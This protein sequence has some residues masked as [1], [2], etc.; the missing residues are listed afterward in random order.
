MG[1]NTPADKVYGR[2]GLEFP[3]DRHTA[4]AEDTFIVIP[5]DAPALSIRWKYG[6]GAGKPALPN[7]QESCHFL[8]FT[9]AIAKAGLTVR[10]VVS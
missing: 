4:A 3:A 5:L 8:E 1:F 7:T 10:W 6:T 9:A 2:H